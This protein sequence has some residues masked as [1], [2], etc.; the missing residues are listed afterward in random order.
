VPRTTRHANGATGLGLVTVAA[1]D[2]A[3]PRAWWASVLERPGIDRDR[4]DLGAL[5]H[6]LRVGR[7]T[8]ELVTP[9]RGDSPLVA[10]LAGRGPGPYAVALTTDGAEG[11][12]DERAAAGARLRLV[13]VA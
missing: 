7:H 4:Q 11:R 13:K 9:S 12:L 8:I 2:L 5:A 1:D 3:E 6:Q 10:L